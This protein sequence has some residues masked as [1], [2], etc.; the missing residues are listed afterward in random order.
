[1]TISR[2]RYD[3]IAKY[4][5]KRRTIRAKNVTRTAV[6]GD[7]N[8]NIYSDRKSYYFA[9]Q[10]TGADEN[11][12]TVLGPTFYLRANPGAGIL[13]RPG[14][15][16]LY[17]TNDAGDPQIVGADTKDLDEQKIDQIALEPNDAYRGFRYLFE[18]VNLSSKSIGVGL[19]VNVYPWQYQTSDNTIVHFFEGTN[20]S[21]HVDLADDG[22]IGP[23]AVTAGRT[24]ILPTTANTHRFALLVFNITK[25]LADEYPLEVYPGIAITIVPNERLTVNEDLQTCYDVLPT[26]EIIVPIK[27][28][29]LEHGQTTIAGDSKDLDVRGAWNIPISSLSGLK[30]TGDTIML[31]SRTITSST[32][33][34]TV[35]MMCADDDFLYRCIATDT[36]VRTPLSTW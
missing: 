31:E 27:A 8:Q 33:T 30:I 15:R 12:N 3:P 14:R 2:S 28:Y 20:A 16:V 35:G 17:K 23:L 26:D 24:S 34:G 7:A 1:M 21:T 5:S 29:Y 19:K 32:D 4:Q 25:H 6:L 22:F 11:G 9:R 18:L 13:A 36:W 10:I